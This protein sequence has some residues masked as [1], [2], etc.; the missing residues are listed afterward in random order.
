MDKL[1]IR[2]NALLLLTHVYKHIDSSFQVRNLECKSL[3]RNTISKSDIVLASKYLSQKKY[4]STQ[5]LAS[6]DITCSITV[7]GI[8]WVEDCYGVKLK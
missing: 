5:A 8:D 4:I 3:L 2:S 7:E 1:K 6:D